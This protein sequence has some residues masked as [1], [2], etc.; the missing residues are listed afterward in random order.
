MMNSRFMLCITVMAPLALAGCQSLDGMCLISCGRTHAASTTLVEFLYPQDEVPTPADAPV[1]RLPLRVGLTFLPASNGVAAGTAAQREDLL[2]KI[3]ERFAGLDY[4]SEIVVIPDYYLRGGTQT[5]GFDTLQR[6]ARLQDLDLVALASYDQV[7]QRDDNRRSLTYLTIVGAF[8]VR[9]SRNETGTLLDLAVIEPRSRSL[10][11]RA[12]G[13]SVLS[14]STTLV[15]QSVQLRN[16]QATGF[17]L[18]LENLNSHFATELTAFEDR[19]RNGTAP[20]KVMQQASS[21]G[22]GALDGG[23]ALALALVLLLARTSHA[24]RWRREFRRLTVRRRS[25]APRR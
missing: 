15:D 17:D 3:K 6:V 11:L 5:T 16:Q 14:A 13:T 21:G 8:L 2:R 19:V 25:V 22:G 23:M 12:G 4:V 24:Q 18:A 10:L 1:L 20:I 7:S 9:G